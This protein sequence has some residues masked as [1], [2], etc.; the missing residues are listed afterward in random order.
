MI[1]ERLLFSRQQE[2]QRREAGNCRQISAHDT[3]LRLFGDLSDDVSDMT[4]PRAERCI[5]VS[6]PKGFA[7]MLNKSSNC[8]CWKFNAEVLNNS[9]QETASN[10]R[11]VIR[12][13]AIPYSNNVRITISSNNNNNNKKNNKNSDLDR[14]CVLIF[15]HSRITNPPGDRPR[16]RIVDHT[17]IR[18]RHQK[19]FNNNKVNVLLLPIMV[20][21]SYCCI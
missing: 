4:S 10:G 11:R 7:E 3:K 14:H 21:V 16:T 17:S 15:T 9:T 1:F 5:R 12:F 20:A 2:K 8:N 6:E 19:H 18:A 13:Y